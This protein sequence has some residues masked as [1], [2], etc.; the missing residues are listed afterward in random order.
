MSVGGKPLIGTVD[1]NVSVDKDSMNK[2]MSEIQEASSNQSNKAMDMAKQASQVASARAYDAE[3]NLAERD[4]LKQEGFLAKR[5]KIFRKKLKDALKDSDK[6]ED[7]REEIRKNKIQTALNVSTRATNL[8]AT[9]GLQLVKGLF[10]FLEGIYSRMRAASPLLRT[11][12]TMFNLAMTLFFMPLGNKLATML[13]PATIDLVEKVT[14]MWEAFEGKSLG[15]MFAHAFDRGLAVLGGYFKN[16]GK[17]LSDQGG[18]L[19]AIGGLISTFGG[20]VKNNMINLLTG[21]L[22]MSKFMIEHLKE[23]ITVIVAFKAVSISLALA[24]MAVTAVSNS[25]LGELGA[26]ILAAAAV[27]VPLVA[28]GGTYGLLDSIGMADGGYVPATPGGEL[29]ILGEGGEGEYV[30]PESKLKGLGGGS[31]N[32]TYN[33]YGYTDSE[34]EGIIRRTT[35]DQVSRYRLQGGF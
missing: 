22:N 13:I 25:L 24:Q 4:A 26:G 5:A 35:D 17:I 20:F 29:H 10:G 27:A 33:I 9:Q 1:L 12:E 21:I 3:S 23:I 7:E 15:E 6:T 31:A 19:G 14:S 32:I 8:I 28:A 18:L 16:I 34:L 11:I 30:I 2:V